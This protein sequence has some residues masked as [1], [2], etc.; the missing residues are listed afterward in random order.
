MFFLFFNNKTILAADVTNESKVVNGQTWTC[1]TAETQLGEP[2]SWSKQRV[3]NVNKLTGTGFPNNEDVYIVA[4]TETNTE[5]TQATTGDTEVDKILNLGSLGT[6][7]KGIVT[8]EGGPIKKAAYGKIEATI[9]WNIEQLLTDPSGYL[10]YLHAPVR[11]FGVTLEA[12]TGRGVDDANKTVQIGSVETFSESDLQE[13][14]KTEWDPEGRVFD[15]KTLEPM[16]GVSVGILDKQKQKVK[17]FGSNPQLTDIAGKYT[18]YV[19]EGDYY[20]ETA[21]PTDYRYVKNLAEI[22]PN[23]QSAYYN[24]YFPQDIVVEK[25]DTPKEVKQGYPDVEHRDIALIS[26]KK[27]TNNPLKI[28]TKAQ[29]NIKNKTIFSGQLSHPLSKVTIKQGNK[30][31]KTLTTNKYGSYEVGINNTEIDPT[32]SFTVECT[33]VD[34]T[35]N[36][37]L[38]FIDKFIDWLNPLVE[39]ADSITIKSEPILKYINGYAYDENKKIIP[40]AQIQVKANGSQNVYYK[41]QADATGFFT[42][43]SRFLPIFPYQLEIIKQNQTLKK[44]LS[45]FAKENQQYLTSKKISLLTVNNSS[46]N[47]QTKIINKNT[48]PGAKNTNQNDFAQPLSQTGG[49]TNPTTQTNTQTNKSLFVIV[50]VIFLLVILVGAIIILVI[51]K[52]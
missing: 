13:C 8:V 9:Q 32:I 3:G 39:A 51:R 50:L 49:S 44:P 19:P 2:L 27:K 45:A 42:I 6:T 36:N 14:V 1:L 46:I 16:P 52:K 33:K 40:Y 12:A 47:K 28:I 10:A 25:I 5:G 26:D 23:Y 15:A 29:Y 35:Q 22:H 7:R 21:P 17:T 20:L 38:S 18:Y 4:V 24:I 48:T 30:T 43:E 11:F 31:L 41:T 37:A 34:L